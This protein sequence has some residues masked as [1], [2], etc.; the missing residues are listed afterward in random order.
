MISIL[1]IVSKSIPPLPEILAERPEASSEV[2]LPR[3]LGP[4]TKKTVLMAE[5]ANETIIIT[6]YTPMYL[7]RRPIDFQKLSAFWP[8]PW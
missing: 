2:A 4:T 8:G 1:P 5:K 3:I 7:N 6:L